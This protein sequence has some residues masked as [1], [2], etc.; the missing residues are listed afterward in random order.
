MRISQL[1]SGETSR[2][3]DPLAWDKGWHI[4]DLA[5]CGH[6]SEIRAWIEDSADRRGRGMVHR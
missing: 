2:R 3:I 5:L 4:G 1:E 6:S